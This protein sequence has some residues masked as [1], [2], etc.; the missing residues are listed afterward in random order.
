MNQPPSAAHHDR[1]APV[2]AALLRFGVLTAALI[3]F[4]GGAKFLSTEGTMITPFDVFHGEPP[5]LRGVSAIVSGAARFEARSVIMLGL[6][7]LIATPILR[8]VFS[9]VIFLFERDVIFVAI[10]L[11]VLAVLLFGLLGPHG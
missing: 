1:A 2:M 7:V 6:L 9:V 5:A 3:V 4:V 8:V 11:F 10:T